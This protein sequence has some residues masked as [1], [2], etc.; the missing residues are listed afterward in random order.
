MGA[1]KDVLDILQQHKITTTILI[2]LMVRE[3]M[4]YFDTTNLFLKKIVLIFDL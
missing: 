2:L 3:Y 4:E 1:L